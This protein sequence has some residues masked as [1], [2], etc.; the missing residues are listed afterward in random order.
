MKQL[1]EIESIFEMKSRD[2][3]VIFARRLNEIDF[4][5]ETTA[6]L[7]NIPIEPWTDIPRAHDSNGNIRLDLF[8][9]ILRNK[10]D[11]DKLSVGET[12]ELST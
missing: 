5:L 3:I 8:A 4:N 1:F 2:Q 7:N 12:V 6:T 11:K 9:F 10:I